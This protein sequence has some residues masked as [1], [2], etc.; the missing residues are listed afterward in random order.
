MKSTIALMADHEV[1]LQAVHVLDAICTEIQ[2]GKDMNRNDVRALLTFLRDFAD[3]CHHVKEEAIFFPALM[4]AGMTLQ[5][6]PLRVMSYEHERG[7]ALT[8]AME[9]ALDRN[10]NQDFL[11]YARRYVELLSEHIEKENYVLFDKADQ[12]LSDEDDQKV[13]DAFEQFENTT[14]GRQT[15]LRLMHIVESL[16]S[17][18]LNAPAL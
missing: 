17:Q 10:N 7:R 18:Y 5:A 3:G 4:Q 16:A 14:V 12:I 15:H 8:A 11:M 9:E 2:H 1:I 13:T 6:G